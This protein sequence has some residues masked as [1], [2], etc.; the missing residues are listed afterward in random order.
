MLVA[1]IA[2]G[3]ALIKSES[4]YARDTRDSTLGSGPHFTPPPLQAK[5]DPLN[6]LLQYS[7]VPQYSVWYFVPFAPCRICC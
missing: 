5:T 7:T 4:A 1:V 3:E 2:A 6:K